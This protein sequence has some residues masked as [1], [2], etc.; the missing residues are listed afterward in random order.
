MIQTGHSNGQA[1]EDEQKIIANTLFYLGQLTDETNASAYTAEDLAAPDNPEIN[2]RELP[3]GGYNLNVT[4]KD[5]GTT[6]EHY[7][8]AIDEDGNKVRSNTVTTT[9]TSGIK[10]FSMVNRR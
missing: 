5:N 3:G 7:V 8:E 1:T 6:Y 4:S 9:V 10:G 2:F